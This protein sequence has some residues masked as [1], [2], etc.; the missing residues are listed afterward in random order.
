M[1]QSLDSPIVNE[2]IWVQSKRKRREVDLKGKGLKDTEEGSN[3]PSSLPNVFQE[4][5]TGHSGCGQK[6]T[7][8]QNNMQR[9]QESRNS[10][11]HKFKKRTVLKLW[12]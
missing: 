3:I 10:W 6:S 5:S 11:P 2:P 12:R 4:G 7:L 1:A 9:K 8:E